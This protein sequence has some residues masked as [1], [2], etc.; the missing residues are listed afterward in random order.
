MSK[1]GPFYKKHLTEWFCC[2]F[3]PTDHQNA[4]TDVEMIDKMME[5]L[6]SLDEQARENLLEAGWGDVYA[7][8]RRTL[9]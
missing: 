2:G 1:L 3:N 7:S 5:H 4:L 8:T 6:E 9:V